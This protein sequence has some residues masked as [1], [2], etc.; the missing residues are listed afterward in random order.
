MPGGR[1]RTL[2]PPPDAVVALGVEMIKYLEAHPNTLH[3]SQWYLGVK[4]I[5]R[6]RWKKLIAKE[7]FGVYY[8]KALQIVGLNYLDKDSKVRDG[9]SHRWQR[10]YFPDLRDQEDRDKDADVERTSKINEN[11]N[12]PLQQSIDL[13]D[14]NIR[15]A[16]E[17][18]LL[19]KQLEEHA[20]KR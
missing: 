9:I 4:M 5:T 15:Q 2:T 11:S 7:E 10:V 1:P 17:I 18:A 8:E 12:A 20:N 6:D 19:K 14:I 16:A 13:H 3:L